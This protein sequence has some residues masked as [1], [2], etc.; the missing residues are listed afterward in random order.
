MI[1]VAEVKFA[2]DH[3]DDVIDGEEASEAAGA[4]F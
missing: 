1:D 3:E 2:G 4:A